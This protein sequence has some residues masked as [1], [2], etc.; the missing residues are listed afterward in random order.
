MTKYRLRV[1]RRN[2]FP[3]IFS[4]MYLASGIAKLS[5]RQNFRKM[6]ESTGF[7]GKL[8]S[9]LAVCIPGGEVVFGLASLVIKTRREPLIYINLSTL[10][11]F[12]G[13]LLSAQRS[14]R[15]VQ[16][17]CFGPL[18]A[19]ING[20]WAVARNCVLMGAGFWASIR[21]QR[22]ES[23]VRRRLVIGVLSIGLG[24]VSLPGF[25]RVHKRPFLDLGRR[26]E[27]PFVI[28]KSDGTV[29]TEDT[30]FTTRSRNMVILYISLAC[31]PCKQLAAN[32]GPIN[33]SMG[34]RLVVLLDSPDTSQMVRREEYDAALYFDDK[35]E[36]AS[37][38]G[39]AA[40]PTLIVV[41]PGTRSI[42]SRQEGLGEIAEWLNVHHG[43]S[44]KPHGAGL[45]QLSGR[46][47]T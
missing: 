38:I 11:I 1:D 32:L 42:L 16:C 29:L 4:V 18:L 31:E 28:G 3:K 47:R 20:R 21:S 15:S 25:G 30:F 36:F 13:F 14:G 46:N 44:I 39:L 6:L 41:D 9:V 45:S 17:F 8:S 12:T 26:I 27:R 34:D 7:G 43:L 22:S 35:G 24:F 23:S 33:E 37:A 2:P 10:S 19:R 5:D 40:A